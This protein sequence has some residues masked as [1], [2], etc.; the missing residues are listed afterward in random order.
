MILYSLIGVVLAAAF[1][2]CTAN[3][4]DGLLIG[5]LALAVSLLLLA[6]VVA[7]CII[8]WWY[9]PAYQDIFVKGKN[10]A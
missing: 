4:I 3:G 8:G 10:A 9:Y 5:D 1:F 7:L 2:L 6:V